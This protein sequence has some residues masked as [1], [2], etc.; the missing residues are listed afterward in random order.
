M[1][2]KKFFWIFFIL[3][4]VFNA[5]Y[6]HLNSLEYISKNP[7]LE[8]GY[9]TLIFGFLFWANIPWIVMGVGCIKNNL[10]FRDYLNPQYAHPY[11][12]AFFISVLFVYTAGSYWLFIA[13][14][15]EMLVRY[16]GLFISNS[17]EVLDSQSLSPNLIQLWWSLG[18]ASGVAAMA[19]LFIRIVR[20]S[21]TAE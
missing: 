15:A 13:D 16:P 8:S 20:S 18:G 19:F 11:L 5:F 7:D 9:H 6:W 17:G 2:M 14:G 3:V 10:T 1:H 4:T 21:S 12:I